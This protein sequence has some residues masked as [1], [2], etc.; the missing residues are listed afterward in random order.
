MAFIIQLVIIIAIFYFLLIRPHRQEQKRHR[1]MVAALD[2]GDRVVTS[3]G[4]IGEI[5]HVDGDELT[6][7][8]GD[9]RVI[10]ERPRIARLQDAPEGAASRK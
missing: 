1:E 5:V 8:T 4:L 6:L 3:G 2:K 9:V 7:K 10:V